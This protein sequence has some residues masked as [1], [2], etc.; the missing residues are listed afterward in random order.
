MG[1]ATPNLFLVGAAKCGTTSLY[2]YLR[3]HPQIFFP[4]PEAANWR[5][6]EPNYFCPELEIA[7]RCAIRDEHEYLSLYSTGA[8]AVLRGDASTN[9]LF[10]EAA[11]ENISRFCSDARILI[12]LRPPVQMMQSYHSELLRHGHEDIVDFREAVEAS[13]DRRMGRRIPQGTCVPK[14]LDYFAISRFAPQVE[15]Y[16][17]VF[18]ESATKIVLLEDMVAAPHETFG[19]ILT[20][21]GV[22]DSHRPEFRVHNETPRQGTLERSI[23]AIYDRFG[24]RRLTESLLPYSARRRFISFVRDNERTDPS[25]Q[26]LDSDLRRRCRPDIERLSK[27]IQRDL[28]H[29]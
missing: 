29:W 1:A 22:D 13:D 21:L 28:S 25:S 6:K 4:P 26:Q 15:R 20:F 14:C 27:L 12:M 18:G 17:R 10:S 8:N 19:Q 3:Q 9:Y 24:V 7:E 2:E 16:L 5:A 23:R 11:A